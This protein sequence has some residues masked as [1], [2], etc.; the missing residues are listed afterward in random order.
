MSTSER[1]HAPRV[2]LGAL[3]AALACAGGAALH[4]EES[5]TV[6]AGAQTVAFGFAGDVQS[7]RARAVVVQCD[8]KDLVIDWVSPAG[9]RLQPGDPMVI[10]DATIIAKRIPQLRSELLAA[11]R[12]LELNSLRLEQQ[13]EDLIDERLRL[14]GE[15]DACRAALTT[16]TAIDTRKVAALKAAADLAD[17]AAAT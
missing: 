17:Q 9:S 15:L 16:A 3:V 5:W 11:Q 6:P 8:A 12:P 13:M 1:F 2:L 4:G 14:R 7:D 10:L